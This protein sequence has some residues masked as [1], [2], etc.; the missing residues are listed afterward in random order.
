MALVYILSYRSFYFHLPS[1]GPLLGYKERVLKFL[2]ACGRALG[3]SLSMLPSQ[4]PSHLGV[5]SLAPRGRPRPRPDG[6]LPAASSGPLGCCTGAPTGI[7]ALPSFSLYLPRLSQGPCG[8]AQGLVAADRPPLL[9]G[10]FSNTSSCVPFSCGSDSELA[11][12]WSLSF[13]MP[14]TWLLWRTV[15]TSDFG[16]H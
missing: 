5:G 4:H 16:S 8:V 14:P 13:G 9:I 15:N 10:S 6:I 2:L 7:L 3:V 1:P 12:L 11:T